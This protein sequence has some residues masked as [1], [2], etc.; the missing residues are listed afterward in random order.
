MQRLAS[1]GK[2]ECSWRL[3]VTLFFSS[4]HLPLLLRFSSTFPSLLSS[5]LPSPA[6]PCPP[7]PSPAL[8]CPPLP[9]PALPEFYLLFYTDRG[10]DGRIAI[11]YTSGSPDII[12]SVR[13]QGSWSYSPA[14]VY[15]ANS[16]SKELYVLGSS[17]TDQSGY[18][19]RTLFITDY[20]ATAS[21][22]SSRTFHFTRI[23]C[24][25]ILFFIYIL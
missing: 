6:L 5:P 21:G 2:L 7:L 24:V 1:S 13:T 10:S 19:P 3:Y 4:L 14:T 18:N 20:G 11:S 23:L 9:S 22:A 15:V 12:S 25:K 16:S 8:P 17:Y